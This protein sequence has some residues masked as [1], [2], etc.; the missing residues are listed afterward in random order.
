MFYVNNNNRTYGET[1]TSI[2]SGDL[3]TS[4]N[5]VDS[6]IVILNTRETL[7]DVINYA[8]ASYTYKELKSMITSAAVNETEIFKVTVTSTD[9]KEAERLANAVAS[10]LPQRIGTIIEGTSVKVDQDGVVT[11]VGAGDATVILETYNGLVSTCKV[12]VPR[13]RLF[14]AYSYFKAGKGG[15]LYF[16]QNNAL[17][18][19]NTF[20]SSRIEGSEYEL[21]GMMKNPS[22]KNLLSGISNAFADSVDTDVNIVYLCSHGFPAIDNYVSPLTEEQIVAS[23]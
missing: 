6:Y 12:N 7:V 4:R 22:K 13:Y 16:T 20:H 14:A 18:M 8:G 23:G 17:S 11:A 5:L 2:S 3:T 19:W 21:V 10:V 15:D 1:S 9:P